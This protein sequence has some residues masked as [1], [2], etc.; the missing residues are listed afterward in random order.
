[1]E[2]WFPH[3]S[4]AGCGLEFS[5]IDVAAPTIFS[6][7]DSIYKWQKAQFKLDKQKKKKTLWAWGR[8]NVKLE[9]GQGKTDKFLCSHKYED[10]HTI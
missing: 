8:Q 3:R 5:S 6:A 9:W 4:S 2:V 10:F 1:M 7:L